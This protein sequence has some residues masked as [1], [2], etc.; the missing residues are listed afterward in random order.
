MELFCDCLEKRDPAPSPPRVEPKMSVWA[1][2]G[3][4]RTRLEALPS[5]PM[6]MLV[7][8]ILALDKINGWNLFAVAVNEWSLIFLVRTG[9][10]T[11]SADCCTKRLWNSY[12]PSNDHEMFVCAAF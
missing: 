1:P 8:V 11:I 3:G 2:P 6:L 9:E 10:R 12:D 4:F 7:E 5:M